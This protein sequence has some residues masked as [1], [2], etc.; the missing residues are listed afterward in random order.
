MEKKT[1]NKKKSGPEIDSGSPREIPKNMKTKEAMAYNQNSLAVER[2]EFSKIRTDLALTN[3][4]LAMN[5]THL[6]YLRT[7]VSLVG[8]SATIYKALPLLGVA[9]A[10]SNGLAVFLL[11]AAVYFL[12]KDIT[13]YP[14]MK[15][16]LQKMEE[17]ASELAKEIESKVYRIEQENNQGQSKRGNN[18]E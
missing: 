1:P 9:S 5:Q 10:F 17:N 16:R 3:T 15:R 12:Y 6:A 14:V 8:S 7:I 13:T 2:T 4:E 18:Q 11:L